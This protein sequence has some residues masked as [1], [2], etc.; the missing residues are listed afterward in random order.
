MAK[1]NLYQIVN[2]I[3]NNQIGVVFD[4]DQKKFLKI[5]ELTETGFDFEF[6][7][8][9]GDYRFLKKE[10][11]ILLNDEI[12]FHALR[13]EEKELL[14]KAAPLY[15]K[16]QIRHFHM[17]NVFDYLKDE[18]KEIEFKS[19]R[20][21]KEE[22]LANLNDILKKAFKRFQ[23]NLDAETALYL[24]L[25]DDL[26]TCLESLNCSF[27]KNLNGIAAVFM[28]LKDK[29]FLDK[30]NINPVD[31]FHVA[32][33]VI[34]FLRTGDK[35]PLLQFLKML[36]E[37]EKAVAGKEIQKFAEIADGEITGGGVEFFY[38]VFDE[39]TPPLTS[40]GGVNP[41]E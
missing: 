9:E 22:G 3:C 23:K 41:V 2:L 39:N 13:P 31:F 11:Y 40:R 28:A 37:I 16:N 32:R 1:I 18:I 24:N 29:E 26:G 7:K 38:N 14:H 35:N 4:T 5:D 12:A 8:L 17:E 36:D 27:Q 30:H 33:E 10:F 34:P 25:S 21:F 15:L 6:W 20:S 19:E